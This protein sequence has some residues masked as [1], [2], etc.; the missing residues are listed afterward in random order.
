MCEL[1]TNEQMRVVRLLRSGMVFIIA[2]RPHWFVSDAQVG[3]EL[4]RYS[5]QSSAELTIEYPFRLSALTLFQCLA[6]AK[7][8]VQS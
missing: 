1:F 7:N 5:S 2:D 3:E 4:R 8:R 6:D